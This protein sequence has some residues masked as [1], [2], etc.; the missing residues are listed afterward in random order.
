M[1]NKI[2]SHIVMTAWSLYIL[3]YNTPWKQGKSYSLNYWLPVNVADT[4]LGDED[5]EIEWDTDCALEKCKAEE[6]KDT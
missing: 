4:L 1:K 3:K 5:I 2:Y 6:E